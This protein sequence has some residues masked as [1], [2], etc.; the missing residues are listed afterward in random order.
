MPVAARL[1]VLL[2]ADAPAEAAGV[3]EDV[4]EQQKKAF[5]HGCRIIS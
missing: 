1:E 4:P 3:P 5:R 2:L